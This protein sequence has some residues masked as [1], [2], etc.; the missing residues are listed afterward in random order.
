MTGI[1]PD[2]IT[3][4]LNIDPDHK[5]VKQKRRNFAHERNQIINDGVQKLIDAGKICEVKYPE[6][7]ANVVVVSKKNGK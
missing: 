6:W 7:L 3:H 1:S 5:P 4:K 2:G